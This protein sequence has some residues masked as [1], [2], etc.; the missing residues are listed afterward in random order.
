[1]RI[2]NLKAQNLKK[3]IAVDITP[4]HDI[5]KITGKNGSGK[6]SVLDAIYWALGGERTVQDKPIREGATK[7]KIQLDLKDYIVTRTF[8]AKGSSLSI[9]SPDG[10]RFLSPQKMLDSL[11]GKISFDPLYFL[12]LTAAD[13]VA[14]L[15]DIVGID[16]KAMEDRKISLYNTRTQVNSNGKAV[17]ALADQCADY[18]EGMAEPEDP[19]DIVKELDMAYQSNA[20]RVQSKESIDRIAQENDDIKLKILRLKTK[21]DENCKVSDNIA[22]NT[23]E[24]IDIDPIQQR[25]ADINQ[26]RDAYNRNQEAL[27]CAQQLNALREESDALTAEIKEIDRQKQE[28]MQTAK[29]PISGLEVHHNEILYSGI[30]LSQASSAEQLKVGISMAMALNPKL[31][32]I[33]ITD[34]SLLDS[35][36]MK[37]IE[38]MAYQNDFQVWIELV[39][40]SGQLGVVIEEG[41]VKASG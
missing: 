29:L 22:A 15:N 41:S 18:I 28:M 14:L 31:R 2:I 30:P 7:A 25:M 39:D 16:F 13:Q 32:V 5:V 40:E 34:G 37:M 21:F 9:K 20:T 38:S 33:R 8:S 4:E 12:R 19:S 10:A 36:S 3:L 17:K 1:M 11:L 35:A 27:K 6:T 26:Q 23:P 24:K